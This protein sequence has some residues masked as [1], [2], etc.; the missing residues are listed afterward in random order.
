[1]STLQEVAVALDT[2]D[3]IAPI[4]VDGISVF[5][6]SIAALA[7]F[8][9]LF[10]VVVQAVDVVAANTGKPFDDVVKAVTD[11][12]TAGQPNAPALAPAQ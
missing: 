3:K 12:L 11:H 5:D 7:P 10:H 1:M 6:G 9:S 4:A 8:L 2:L